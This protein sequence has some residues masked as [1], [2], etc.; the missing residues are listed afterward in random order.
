MSYD[1]INRRDNVTKHHTSIRESEQVIKNY[2]RIGA[3]AQKI[4][5]KAKST[6][7]VTLY[8]NVQLVGFAYY[9]KYFTTQGDCGGDPIGC[10][11]VQAEDPVTG[12]DTLT[13]G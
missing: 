9:A 13:S 11:I 12:K 2:L 10:P 7:I 8:A 4:N 6:S 5:R 1:L 3:P